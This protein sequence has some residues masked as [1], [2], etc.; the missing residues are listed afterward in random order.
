MDNEIIVGLDIG[1]TKIACF[2]GHRAENGRVNILG[3]GKTESV[4][5][6]R[7]VVVNIELTAQSIKK[8]VQEASLQ[9]NVEVGEVYV[10]IAGQHIKSMQNRGN[11]MVNHKDE[12]ITESDVNRLIEDQY[13][14]MLQPGEEII[15]VLPQDFIV[16]G[17]IINTTPV[18]VAGACL[19]G[20][21]HIITGHA[22]NIKNISRS[23]RSAGLEVKGL[24]LEPIASAEAVLDN[25]DKDAGV[26]L[27]DIGGGTT[28]I[29]IFHEGIIRH[30]AVITMGGNVITD[31][32]KEGCCIMRNQA[33]ALKIK[34]GSC[35]ASA[36]KEDDVIAIPGIRNKAPR[37][38]SMKTLAGIIEARMHMI[39]EQ[40]YREIKISG[41]ERK[42]IGGIV[43]TGGGA[44]LKHAVQLT[45][46][47]TGIDTRIGV[48]NEHLEGEIPSEL[49]HPMHATG[50]GLVI[51]GIR[52]SENKNS[53][54]EIPLEEEEQV[55]Q[56]DPVETKKETTKQKKQ[57]EKVF[58]SKTDSFFQDWIGKLFNDD[59]K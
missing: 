11:I 44:M 50:I 55:P 51:H 23:V 6:N 38:I 8:A 46:F 37:E 18:G 31:D 56:V 20:N 41:Y 3:S 49:N 47:I 12:I 16:D 30:T 39:L 22:A 36:N 53:K 2:I 25:R 57:K 28:D 29:A 35:L 59:I 58:G 5:V 14:L 45:E 34:F 9:A 21:F 40:V 13:R 54:T 15:H 10:G 32:I 42:L 4:G 52:E 7:G 19:E 24:V 1:T 27:V 17:E 26:A 43:L 48:P 33:E